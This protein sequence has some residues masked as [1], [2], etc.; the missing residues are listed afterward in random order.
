MENFVSGLRQVFELLYFISGIVL[1]V[2]AFYGLQQIRL[3]KTDITTKNKRQAV[4]KSIEYL[5]KFANKL[6]PQSTK[7]NEFLSAKGIPINVGN[8][9]FTKIIELTSSQKEILQ[10]KYDGYCEFNLNHF[11]NELELLAAAINSGLADED[12]LIKPMGRTF[13]RM[14]E[15]LYDHICY[16]RFL[17]E[18]MYVNIVTLYTSWKEQTIQSE[19][20]N[21]KSEIEK[22]L[23]CLS[24]KPQRTFIGKEV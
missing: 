7:C 3:L 20:I 22:N 2:F 13:C 8:I 10:K 17:S 4:E 21:Q 23:A 12:L 5:D 18:D 11:A 14:I 19:L 9:D 16:H 24:V 15:K 1:A 6:I